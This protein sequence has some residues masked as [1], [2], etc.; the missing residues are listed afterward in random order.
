MCLRVCPILCG[1]LKGRTKLLKQIC[2][3]ENEF[4]HLYHQFTNISDE[5]QGLMERID[6]FKKAIL[7]KK[8]PDETNN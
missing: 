8:C 5:Y 7:W 2:V 6:F 3:N 1:G 4:M